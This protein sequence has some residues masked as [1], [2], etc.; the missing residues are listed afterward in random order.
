M[1]SRIGEPLTA[2]SNERF[3]KFALLIA[4]AFIAQTAAA[5]DL[6]PYR[7]RVGSE[8]GLG[9]RISHAEGPAFLW[10]IRA[11][12]SGT[13]EF[14]EWV[15]LAFESLDRDGRGAARFAL[16][17]PVPQPRDLEHRVLFLRNGRLVAS[18]AVAG[19]SDEGPMEEPGGELLDFDWGLGGAALPAGL[20]VS[21]TQPWWEFLEIT[22]TNANA[23]HPDAALLVDSTA[24][25][26]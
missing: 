22:A 11:R 20:V 8:T 4:L 24:W 21:D 14:G 10:M 7:Y 5:Q 25:A 3:M 23:A 12:E 26:E 19:G 13:E 6:R 9:L 17:S 15:S 1:Q 18:S 2:P 16:N